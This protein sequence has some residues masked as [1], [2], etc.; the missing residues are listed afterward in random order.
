MANSKSTKYEENGKRVLDDCV[1]GD[2]VSEGDTSDEEDIETGKA[3]PKRTGFANRNENQRKRKLAY[4]AFAFAAVV[5][6]SA[7]I[8]GGIYASKKNSST[9]V[10]DNFSMDSNTEIIPS[11]VEEED[12]SSTV[13]DENDS[14]P[15]EVPKEEV[16]PS[17]EEED[18][19]DSVPKG[20]TFGLPVSKENVVPL[21]REDNKN[22]SVLK[23]GLPVSEEIDSLPKEDV[24]PSTR[25]DD[26]NDSVP[27]GD[28][29]G[30]LDEI[31]DLEEENKDEKTTP[32]KREDKVKK[33][34]WPELVGMTG[35]MA[36]A[37]I[38]TMYG[39]ETYE[40]VVL[41]E[42]S[43]VTRDYRF[44]RIRIFTNTEGIVTTTP[45]IG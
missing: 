20:D 5:L 21:T 9:I 1:E 4:V 12:S 11:I 34:K 17:I 45:V 14:L 19:N 16:I 29:L 8:G 6:T 35:E 18:E 44:N 30:L 28:S 3:H 37:Q 27:K 33:S 36:K 22:D 24:L 31:V 42:G 40:I 10:E 26:E 23:G 15:K 32:E 13:Q 2:T 38:Q 25:E 7:A 39:E 41:L 43:P